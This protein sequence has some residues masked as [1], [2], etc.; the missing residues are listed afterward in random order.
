MAK[1]IEEEIR[2][3]YL[4]SDGEWLVEKGKV[5]EARM[6]KKAYERIK[7]QQSTISF[8]KNLYKE[9]CEKLASLEKDQN[10][11]EEV[12]KNAEKKV[13]D[14]LRSMESAVERIRNMVDE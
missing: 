1:T 7:E 6:L 10:E 9:K 4:S 8:Y 3:Y 14:S 5:K 2:E 13:K 11:R 12:L